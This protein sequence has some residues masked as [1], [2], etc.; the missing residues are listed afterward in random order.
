MT[1]IALTQ[2]H[3]GQTVAA[4]PGDVVIIRLA[5]NPTT[6]YR[7]EIA[8]GPAPSGDEFSGS[9]GAPGAA[10]ERVLRFAVPPA[11]TMRVSAELRRAWEAGAVPQARFEVII[12]TH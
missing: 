3:S 1:E 5:E 9:S 2:A 4:R 10:G 8:S 7:W 11:G 6:G 12:E